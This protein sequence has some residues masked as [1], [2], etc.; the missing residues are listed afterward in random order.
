MVKQLTIDE[1]FNRYAELPLIDVRSPGEYKKGHIPEAH[2]IPLFEDDERAEVGTVYVRQ[3]REKAIEL[4]YKFVTPKLQQFIDK[5]E[6]LSPDK[7]VVVHC[8]RGG[9]RS[10]SFAQHL[11]DNGFREV[12]TIKGGYKAFRNYVLKTF[13]HPFKLNILGGYTGSGK[14]EI[15]K[16]LQTRGEQ[17]VDLEGLAHHKGSAFG[18]IGQEVQP[19]VEQFENNL[20]EAFQQLDFKQPIWLE[21]E[22][23]NIGRVQIPINLFRQI[24]ELPLI[25]LDIPAEERAVK[26]V[27]EY[28]QCEADE[29]AAAIQRI[30]KRLGGLAVKN[31]LQ[32]IEEGNYYEVT[33]IALFYY[34]KAYQ[35][36]M[37]TRDQSKVITIPLENTDASLNAVK[38]LQEIEHYV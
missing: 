1:Y 10:A 30:H 37:N 38:I 24:R 13:D 7:K 36:G 22:S 12:Y 16:Q 32:Y 34:D 8:W 15:L 28:G 25:F 11:L 33:K 20:F 5:S 31:A 27:A 17:V 26:L 4:G 9:M 21:D 19:T 2:S 3:S 35:K 23:H 18:G 14:T 6:A 29:L